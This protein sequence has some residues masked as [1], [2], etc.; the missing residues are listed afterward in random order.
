MFKENQIIV[1]KT[2]QPKFYRGNA[3]NIDCI[4]PGD[5]CVVVRQDMGD[6][7]VKFADGRLF[8]GKAKQIWLPVDAFEYV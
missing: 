4:K 5:R 8:A 6:V 3:I 2:E 1:V 7:L